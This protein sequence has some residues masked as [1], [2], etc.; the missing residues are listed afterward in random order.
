[1]RFSISRVNTYLEN[2]WEHWCKYIAEY[3]ELPDPKRTQYMDR[4][5]IFHTAME[6]MAYQQGKL[7]KEQVSKL[8]L[9]KH[10]HSPFCDEA[11]ESGLVAIERYLDN[12]DTVNFKDVIETEKEITCELENGH[13]FIGYVDAVVDNHDG[14]VSLIDYKTYSESPGEDKM[15]YSLQA[16][17]Y[18]AVMEKLGYKVKDFSFECI[19]PRLKINKRNYIFKRI[20]FKYNQYRSDETFEQFCEIAN[21]IGENPNLRMYI[22]PAHR[23]PNVYDYLYKVYIG[24]IAEDL[25]EFIEKSFKKVEKKS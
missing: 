6:I 14:T 1:M 16:N 10:E 4:G 22:P 9:E 20:K 11:R 25:D 19:N 23:Q 24:D 15:K 2:P 12:G 5:T 17:M 18:M 21:M 7:T 3:K 8:A 13:T